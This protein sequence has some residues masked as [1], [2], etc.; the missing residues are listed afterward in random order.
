MKVEIVDIDHKGNGI[1]RV[2]NK[3]VFVPKSIVGD[4]LD[5]EIVKQHKKYD[6]GK[7]KEILKKS[8]DRIDS[9]C[10]YYSVCGGCNISNL[11]YSKQL[12]YKKNKVVNIFNRYLGMNINPMIIGSNNRYEYRV[13][14]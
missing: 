2:N 6:E 12:E 9:I 14:K 5:I 1:A 8:V 11:N 7:I 13:I 10:P 3:I 4:C